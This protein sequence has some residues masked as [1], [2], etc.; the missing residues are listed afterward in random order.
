MLNARN[1]PIVRA[2]AVLVLIWAVAFAGY[3][4]AKNSKVTPEKVRAFVE[5]V[6]FAGMS[7]AERAAAIQKLAAMLNAL[8]LE[9]RQGLRMDRTAY[10]WFEKMTES[11]KSQFLEATMP[12]GFKQMLSAF[13]EMP[14]DKRHKVVDQAMKQ[15]KEANQKMAAGGFKPPGGGTNAPPL[16][17]ELQDQV[18]KIGLQ[19]FYSQSSA[20]TKAEMAPLLEE[21][22]RSMESG[23]LMRGQRPE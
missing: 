8:S 17:K 15:M 9:E 23:R 22:Q 18:T 4:F 14:P 12:T 6:D 16:S 13:E 10:E 7:A 3:E 11:E 21:M 1:R 2:V 19:S 20:E 5:S